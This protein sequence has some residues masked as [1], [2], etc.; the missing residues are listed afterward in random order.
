MEFEA[1]SGNGLFQEALSGSRKIYKR[2]MERFG[3]ENKDSD[4]TKLLL[5]LQ[6]PDI[7][8]I[9]LNAPEPWASP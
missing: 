6:F 3:K 8:D 1:E 4:V 9:N 2:L 5:Y 7:E